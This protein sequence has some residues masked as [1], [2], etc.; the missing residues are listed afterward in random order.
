[1]K[2]RLQAFSEIGVDFCGPFFAT[3][4]RSQVKRHVLV[5]VCCVTRAVNIEV[6]HALDG[7]SCLAALE[8]HMAR[9][10]RP[11]YVNSDNGA[12]FIASARH[13]EERLKILRQEG[14]PESSRWTC[15]IEWYFNPPASPTWTGHVECFVKLVKR[16]LRCLKP[17]L[18]A[19]FNDEELT[20]L[21]VQTQ[22]F[23]NMRPLLDIRPECPPLTPADFLLTGNPRLA[24]LP[25]VL[26]EKLT[27]ETRKEL[28]WGNLE[29]VWERFKT[30]YVLSL[31]KNV[32]LLPKGRQ[33]AEK[34]AVVILDD[35]GSKIPGKWRYGVVVKAYDGKDG[36]QRSFDVL[37]DGDKIFKRNFRALGRLPRP[38]V[39]PDGYQLEVADSA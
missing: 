35:E 7:K 9:Y 10:G 26:P 6:C 38:S 1:M 5:I 28:I 22:G 31:R 23:L 13:L 19:T 12:N 14:V 18:K 25:V 30:G 15:N 17:R 21:I 37:V 39:V 29:E 24:N 32:R 8:R 3:V 34:D 16:A 2:G 11:T 33:I 20:T 36:T 4:G 27:L